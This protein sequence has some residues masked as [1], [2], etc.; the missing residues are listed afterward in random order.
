MGILKHA[1]V[2]GI[3][4]AMEG[5]QMIA[6]PNE[7]VAAL[8]CLDVAN[9][10]GGP[11]RLQQFSPETAV[12]IARLIQQRYAVLKKA[13]LKVDVQAS[14]K[15]ASER[16]QV[17][18]AL[19]VTAAC[20][21]K[22]AAD[23]GSLEDVDLN[24]IESAGKTD[25]LAKADLEVQSVGEY[26]VPVGTSK[27]PGQGEIGS[28]SR[29]GKAPSSSPSTA[30]PGMKL[31]AL[32]KE[33]ASKTAAQL[34][35]VKL[36]G[37]TPAVPLK[38]PS[39]EKENGTYDHQP[40]I[41]K[42]VTD[43]M[44]ALRQAA[45][46]FPGQGEIGS[47]SRAGKAPSSSP[48]TADPG[49]KL[50][51]LEKELASKT[52]AQLQ[53]VMLRGQTPALRQAAFKVAELKRANML[54]PM[55]EPSVDPG[56]A[57][58]NSEVLGDKP[59]GSTPEGTAEL[60]EALAEAGVPLDQLSK[61]DFVQAVLEAANNGESETPTETPTNPNAAEASPTASGSDQA[62]EAAALAELR[63]LSEDGSLTETSENT[64]AA[65]A[66]NDTLANADLKNQKPGEYSKE[67]GK[68]E[69][70]ANGEGQVGDLS[71]AP[72]APST[73]PNTT[74][75]QEAKTADH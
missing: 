4:A 47:Q 22:Y 28:Q 59:I 24:T 64:M 36:R 11:E 5:H 51:A 42:S 40:M 58:L 48:S 66:K 19:Q 57:V 3:N 10:L 9:Q 12:K 52:A 73:S 26:V 2:S 45:F 67:Q 8:V 60:I 7:K 14:V 39:F 37:Q 71:K 1:T 61:D 62:K 43:I 49:M 35:Q 32:E 70:G 38:E 50:S 55:Q 74:A 13:G 21:D 17:Q 46:K 54:P 30:D 68:S 6:W 27:F 15:T 16:D 23:N 33:L 72:K 44:R 18:H 29:A 41:L 63:K 31:S 56:D 69:F 53:Q 65:A 25:P 75:S 34:Q 20:L